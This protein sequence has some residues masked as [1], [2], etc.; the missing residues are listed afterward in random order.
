MQTKIIAAIGGNGA[1]GKSVTKA[2]LEQGAA[3]V[4]GWNDEE[5]WSQFAE[6]FAYAGDQVTG[7]QVDVTDEGSVQR[8]FSTIM[9]K[10]GRVDA[11]IYMAGVF[12]VGPELWH[13]DIQQLKRMLDI[14]TVGAVTACKYAIPPM[15]EQNSG[16]I[17]FLPAKSVLYG[18]PHFGT[19]AV[20]KGALVTLMETLTAELLET[21][22]AV[23]CVMPDAMITPITSSIPGAPLD[24]MVTTEA[25]A[26]I[27][28]SA[29][30]SSGNIVRGSIL[31]CFGK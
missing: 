28:V 10:Y 6:E 23:N 5:K 20:S 24:K 12:A 1:L 11:L 29:C 8:F 4:I 27:I 22:I 15:L 9:D 2:F 3:V 31:R 25:V 7:L 16:N 30:M 18:T 21:N 26:E 19:Y 13:M 14:N 17:I